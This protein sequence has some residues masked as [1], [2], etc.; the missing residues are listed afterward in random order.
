MRLEDSEQRG[1]EEKR[2]RRKR[3]NREQD[4]FA[5]QILSDL[6]FFLVL[7]GRLVHFVIALR[8]EEE[9]ADLAAHHRHQPA[10]QGGQC[11]VLEHEHVGAKK[12]DRTDQMERLVDTAMVI[13]AMVVPTLKL[14]CL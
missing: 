5:M 8:L 4:G 14:E 2:K 3:P 11:R 6:D 13:V 1:I 7:V 10:Y 9:M 12:T